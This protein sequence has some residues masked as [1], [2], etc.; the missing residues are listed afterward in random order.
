MSITCDS[1]NACPTCGPGCN[2]EC[3]DGICESVPRDGGS[4][5]S[6]GTKRRVLST[7]SFRSFDGI[8]N[9]MPWND[10]VWSNAGGGSLTMSH[11]MNLRPNMVLTDDDNSTM[12]D[13]DTWSNHPGFLGGTWWKDF[14]LPRAA[15]AEREQSART[16]INQ[17]YSSSG[18]CDQLTSTSDRLNAAIAQKEIDLEEAGRGGRRVARREIPILSEKLTTVDKNME[19]QCAL[20]AEEEAEKQ[21]LYGQVSQ[22]TQQQQKPGMSSTTTLMIGGVVLLGVGFLLYRALSRPTVINTK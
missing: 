8:G 15:E 7:G 22:L 3:V 10:T 13:S 6:P 19:T 12:P 1:L 20:E 5:V 4:R 2:Y 21:A 18:T 11:H 14:W 16:S 9:D 17:Q